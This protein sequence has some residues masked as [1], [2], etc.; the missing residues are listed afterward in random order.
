MLFWPPLLVPEWG[1][2]ILLAN[3]VVA[4]VGNL[5]H[6]CGSALHTMSPGENR[7]RIGPQREHTSRT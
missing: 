4:E 5:T 6:F 3:D 7:V 1:L 2:L